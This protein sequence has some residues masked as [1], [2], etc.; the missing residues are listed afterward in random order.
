MK[1]ILLYSHDTYGLGNIRRIVALAEHLVQ[2]LPGV[3][4]L[5]L[6]GSPMMQAFRLSPGIDYIKLPC[7]HRNEQGEYGSRFLDMPYEALV[8]LRGD[9]ILNTVLSFEPSLILV[10]KK[11]MGV[12]NEL[13]PMLDVLRRHAVRP[14]MAL[15][16]REILDTPHATKAVWERNEYLKCIEE[17]YDSVLVLGPK[18]V[19]DTAREYGFNPSVT[20]MVRHCGYVHKQLP[21]RARKTVR[22][23]L[24]A[25]NRKLILLT[26]GGGKDGFPLLQTGLQ[27]L[28]PRVDSHGLKIL[29]VSGPEMSTESKRI[30]NDYAGPHVHATDFTDDLLSY[31]NAADLVVSMAGYNTVTELLALDK[32][33]VLVPRIK[34]SLEQ[35]IRASRLDRLGLCTTLHPEQLNE[36]SLFDAIETT[37]AS[38]RPST[39]DSGVC[40]NALDHVADEVDILLA[41]RFTNAF[42]SIGHMGL[43]VNRFPNPGAELNQATGQFKASSVS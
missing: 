23:E 36:Q 43:L 28:M 41:E 6:S 18:N 34:P 27:A 9:L 40:M 8:K 11:P 19:F 29:V 37:L 31:M 3:S 25:G 32:R 38:P 5:I 39:R 10:D 14:R 22:D 21:V 13:R 1:R 16:L 24:G 42:R 2:S 7:L 4:L 20:A 30:L 33:V 35:W 17:F 26:A 15:V 12:E